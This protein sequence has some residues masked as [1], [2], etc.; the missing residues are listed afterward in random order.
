MQHILNLWCH[1]FWKRKLMVFPG[2][3]W[4]GIK[5]FVMFSVLMPWLVW[6]VAFHELLHYYSCYQGVEQKEFAGS[7]PFLKNIV[8]TP[9]Y[10]LFAGGRDGRV[11]WIKCIPQTVRLGLN[12][13]N[14]SC[15]WII[16]LVCSFLINRSHTLFS[17]VQLSIAQPF[18]MSE[19]WCGRMAARYSVCEMWSVIRL[20]CSLSAVL[21]NTWCDWRRSI[22]L[23]SYLVNAFVVVFC[24]MSCRQTA[25]EIQQTIKPW[26]WQ[27]CLM[28][29]WRCFYTNQARRIAH[30]CG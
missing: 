2:R 23:E 13:K 15:R 8:G 6:I 3:P 18:W 28:L 26:N 9:F 27:L 22:C 16:V 10:L 21:I 29:S 1:W 20:S 24:R 7:W 19:T 30:S 5:V 12:W 17:N 14:K 25:T 4:K 11:C